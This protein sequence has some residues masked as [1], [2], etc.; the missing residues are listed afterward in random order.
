MK[1]LAI[2]AVI[3]LAVNVHARAADAP[4]PL[5]T[6][7]C[8]LVREK[9][10]EYGKAR[11]IGWAIANGYGVRDIQIAKKCLATAKS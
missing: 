4:K 11:S 1:I 3:I 9:V 2:S 8:D 5:L 6:I 10:A 7:D